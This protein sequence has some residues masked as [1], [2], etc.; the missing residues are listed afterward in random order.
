MASVTQ[1]CD[2]YCHWRTEDAE[3]LCSLKTITVQGKYSL[4]LDPPWANKSTKTKI[5]H[6]KKSHDPFFLYT[7][8]IYMCTASHFT[9]K[10]CTN[11][12]HNNY[13]IEVHVH[14][15]NWFFKILF[16]SQYTSI[17]KYDNL[18]RLRYNN[19]YSWTLV[20]FTIVTFL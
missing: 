17:G 11:N 2:L 12:K 13:P 5:C 7:S 19:K 18:T 6:T 16:F 20:L 14:V 3:N 4:Q 1:L 10:L 9:L 8:S 15:L